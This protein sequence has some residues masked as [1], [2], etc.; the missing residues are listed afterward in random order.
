MAVAEAFRI[1][2]LGYVLLLVSLG[3]YSLLTYVLAKLFRKEDE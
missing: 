1:A 3:M 2:A